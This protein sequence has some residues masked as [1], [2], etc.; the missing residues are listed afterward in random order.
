MLAQDE[1]E[2]VRQA[3][4]YNWNT[5]IDILTKLA[6]DESKDVR[7]AVVWNSKVPIK[8]LLA[9]TKDVEFYVARNALEEMGHLIDR[10][11]E[12]IEKLNEDQ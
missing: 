9:L 6:Q 1:D 5:P 11:N 3:V 2:N 10:L 8:T 7:L 12:V 4:A